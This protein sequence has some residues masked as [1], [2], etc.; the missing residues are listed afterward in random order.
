M[1]KFVFTSMS[2][3]LFALLFNSCSSEE[4]RTDDPKQ[5]AITKENVII[6]SNAWINNPYKL[7]VI[8]FI[9]SDNDSIPGFRKRISKILLEE[10]KFIAQNMIRE[11]YGNKSFGL[12]LINDSLVDIYVIKG[13]RAKSEYPYSSSVSMPKINEELNSFYNLYPEK[14]LSEHNLII[15]PSA[16]SDPLKPG[17]VPF[18]GYGRNCFALDYPD[19]D[20]N[21]LG[22][23]GQIGSLATKWIGGLF[24]ELGHG[25]NLPHNWGTKSLTASYGTALMGYGN[26]ALGKSSVFVTSTSAAILNTS[27]T[28]SSTSRSDW[29][30]SIKFNLSHLTSSFENNKIILKGRFTADQTITNVL[31]YHDKKPYGSNLDYDAVTFLTTPNSSNEFIIESPLS[32]FQGSNTDINGEYELRLHFLFANG[33]RQTKSFLYSITNNIPTLTEVKQ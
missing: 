28:F 7:N 17:G 33:T 4:L 22:K 9:P 1:R 26:Y 31:V 16:T 13:K 3:C 27:Q 8:Y 18:Y 23:S 6:E 24:H 32:E 10:Q 29:Y 15:M 14:K 12:K 19:F 11:G 21:N 2:V 20:Y 5:M 30:K 25:L